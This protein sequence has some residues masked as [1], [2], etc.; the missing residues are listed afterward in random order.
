MPAPERLFGL[1]G[2]GGG[3]FT[4]AGLV[5][6]AILILPFSGA[7]ADTPPDARLQE[8]ERALERE[9]A[10]AE[11]LAA[12]AAR[13]AREIRSLAERQVRAAREA[14]A[15]EQRG[16][17][18]R[19]RIDGL[20]IEE[21]KGLEDL[22][23]RRERLAGLLSALGRLAR[24]PPEAVIAQGETP[25]ETL[26]GALL[27][28]GTLREVERESES[29]RQDLEALARLRDS[30]MEE[31]RQLGE[32]V[33]AL[34]RR[35]TELAGLLEQRRAIEAET[36]KA[37]A[38]AERQM[39]RLGGEAADLRD[40]IERL[41][42]EEAERRKAAEAQ[43]RQREAERSAQARLR[44]SP[45]VPGPEAIAPFDGG[46]ISK[47]RGR[48][49]RPVSGRV[50]AR[51]GSRDSLGQNTVG[52]SFAA[53][54]GALVIAPHG[55]TIAFAG[56]FRGYGQLLI[57]DHG[58]GYH[59]LLSGL[60]RIDVH[61]GQPLLAGEPVGVT[62]SRSEGSVRLYMELRRDSRP[63]DPLPWLAA[64]ATDKVSG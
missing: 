21:Q 10:R 45:P 25:Q 7:G 34:N 62:E 29:L 44:P 14:Q 59:S 49:L 17:D 36:R 28:R 18:L 31:E 26:R 63:I 33:A 39:A 27:L 20:R 61:V 55:G 24:H 5:L 3:L 1:A 4:L 41:A 54:P 11:E 48:L 15:L 32:T 42:R 51:F 8:V 46:P 60:G 57:I 13:T 6:A 38:G 22:A 30:T 23:V 47:A 58:E 53:P 64:P 9:A 2:P 40:L 19:E 50:D 52:I 43:A 56:P 37:Q 12:E 16:I 35:Q